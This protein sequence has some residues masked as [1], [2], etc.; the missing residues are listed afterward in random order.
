[1]NLF[2]VVSGKEINHYYSVDNYYDEEGSLGGSCMRFDECQGYIDFYATNKKC[3]LLILRD[4]ENKNLIKGRALLWSLDEPSGRIFM[5]RIYT[6]NYSDET[7]FKQYAKEN[8]F[9]FKAEQSYSTGIEIIDTKSNTK[10]Q[11]YLKVNLDNGVDTEEFPYVDTLSFYNDDEMY[12][13]NNGSECKFRLNSTE[14]GMDENEYYEAEV[15][16]HWSEYHQEE[17]AENRAKWCQIGEDWVYENEAIYVNNTNPRGQYAVPDSDLVVKSNYSNKWFLKERCV[18]SDYLKDWLFEDSVR[19]IY[20]DDISEDF[21]IIHK[22]E[23][24]KLIDD[25]KIVKKDNKYYYL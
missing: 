24:Q 7:F 6:N 18:Y 2:D 13:A 10:G 5:D 1:M 22:K 14:G 9:L 21:D 12:I 11:M 17:I 25:E 19:K 23:I 3:K 15:E 4:S 16:T 20:K 8:V